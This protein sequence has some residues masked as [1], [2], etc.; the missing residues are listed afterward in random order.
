MKFEEE[1]GCGE[2]HVG[3]V[4]THIVLAGDPIVLPEH[5]W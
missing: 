4:I 5:A 1:N 2:R 3:L